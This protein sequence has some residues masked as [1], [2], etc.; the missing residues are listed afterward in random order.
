MEKETFLWQYT[1]SRKKHIFGGIG[2]F[3]TII[4]KIWSPPSALDLLNILCKVRKL[5]VL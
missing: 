2:L 3:I 4:D 1:S 5:F